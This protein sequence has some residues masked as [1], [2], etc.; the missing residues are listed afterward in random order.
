MLVHVILSLSLA[1]ANLHATIPLYMPT[2]MHT[3]NASTAPHPTLPPPD[4]IPFPSRANT[5]TRHNT[6]TAYFRQ[7]LRHTYGAHMS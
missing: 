6:D 2:R 1:A 3:P 5:Y 7:H 4:F